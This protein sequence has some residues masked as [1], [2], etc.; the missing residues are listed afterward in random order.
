MTDLDAL[1][2]RL[3][4]ALVREPRVSHALAYG[5]RTQVDA[6]GLPLGDRWSDLEYWAFLAGGASLDPFAFLGSL[7]PVALA[8]VNPFGTPNVVLPDLTRVELHVVPGACLE[9]VAGWPNAGGDPGAMILKDKGGRLREVLARRATSPPFETTLPGP[10]AEYDGVLHG[11]V[12]GSAV[13]ARGEELRA[14]DGMSW[15]R[16]GLLRLAR[17]ADG[18]PQPLNPARRAEWD[19]SDCWYRALRETGSGVEAARAYLRALELSGALAGVLGLNPR[20]E[21]RAALGARLASLTP[22]P[23]PSLPTREG[24]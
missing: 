24:G 7:V 3:R 5:S 6:R 11:L 8:V 12:F 13:L 2:A 22:T 1:D 16:A 10:Q 20:R 18:A 14:W 15:V 4:E 23:P 17:S 21:V 19:L 9:E